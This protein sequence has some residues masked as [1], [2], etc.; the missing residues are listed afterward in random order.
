MLFLVG[1][2]NQ[3]VSHSL[4]PYVPRPTLLVI[5]SDFS[6]LQFRSSMSISKLFPA[7]HAWHNI[8]DFRIGATRGIFKL[9]GWVGGPRPHV[10]VIED[11]AF[12]IPWQP[13]ISATA[14]SGSGPVCIPVCSTTDYV[15]SQRNL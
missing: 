2:T 6:V 12:H 5:F 13:P 15:I 11:L 4:K 7:K 9:G 8:G 14:A 1:T 10:G 3:H